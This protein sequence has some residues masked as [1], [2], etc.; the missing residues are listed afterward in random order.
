MKVLVYSFHLNDHTLALRSSKSK[1]HLV[2]HNKQY[3]MKVLLKK[4]KSYIRLEQQH[5]HA[6][7]LEPPYTV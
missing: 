3:H 6:T 2:Q 4:L 1:T 7:K 5:L